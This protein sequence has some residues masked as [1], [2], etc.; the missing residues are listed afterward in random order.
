[1]KSGAFCRVP[2]H[3]AYLSSSLVGEPRPAGSRGQ[4]SCLCWLPWQAEQR[5]VTWNLKGQIQEEVP[6]GRGAGARKE[7]LKKKKKRI[8][9]SQVVENLSSGGQSGHGYYVPATN[10]SCVPALSVYF[11]VGGLSILAGLGLRGTGSQVDRKPEA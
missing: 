2:A 9:G 7:M 5:K 10:A 3:Y 8:R 1:M 11:V 4:A 6:D